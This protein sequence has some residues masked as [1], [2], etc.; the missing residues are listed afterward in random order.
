MIFLNNLIILINPW[1]MQDYRFSCRGFSKTNQPN[2]NCNHPERILE[3]K[4]QSVW[5]WQQEIHCVSGTCLSSHIASFT[6]VGASC[7]NDVA[8]ALKVHAENISSLMLDALMPKDFLGHFLL[9][10]YVGFYEETY[11]KIYSFA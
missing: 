4:D 7:S 10:F 8:L 3:S 9:R 2:K 11:R 5:P 1:C 6:D